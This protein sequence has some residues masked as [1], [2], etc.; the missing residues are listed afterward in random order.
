MKDS[1]EI[2]KMVLASMPKTG[3]IP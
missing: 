3:K 1:V 2:C